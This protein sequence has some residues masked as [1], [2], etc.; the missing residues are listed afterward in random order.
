VQYLNRAMESI[1]INRESK[2]FVEAA[3][4]LDVENDTASEAG[5]SVSPPA[6]TQDQRQGQVNSFLKFS[7]QHILQHAASSGAS[8]AAAAA[9][10]AAASR[11]S[12]ELISADFAA[13]MSELD[14]KRSRFE[15]GSLPFW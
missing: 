7:I 6:S 3:S 12:N 14:A 10:A 9:V 1:I 5:K 15:I 2:S 13:A 4:D 8:G 11:R